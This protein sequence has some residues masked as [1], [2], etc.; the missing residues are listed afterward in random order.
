VITTTAKT[1]ALVEVV[2]GQTAGLNGQASTLTLSG[3]VDVENNSTLDLAGVISNAKGVIT[4]LGA[5]NAT[6]LTVTAAT[7]TLTG[8]GTIDLAGAGNNDI[9]SNNGLQTLINANNLIEGAGNIGD[10]GSLVFVNQSPGVV[11]ANLAT[12]A[13]TI[14]DGQT[15]EN[16]GVLESTAAGGLFN[17]NST[18][19]DTYGTAAGVLNTGEIAATGT[20]HVDLQNSNIYGGTLSTTGTAYI[21]VVSGQTAGL[22][23]TVLG[24]SVNIVA[25]ANFDVNN[26]SALYLYGSIDNA[27]TITLEGAANATGIDLGNSLVT[28]SGGGRLVLGGTGDNYIQ[29][30]QGNC[31]L[32]NVSNTI[33]GSGNIGNGGQMYLTNESAGT[34]DALA[35]GLTI[36]LGGEEM[37]NAGTLEATGGALQVD[38]NVFNTGAIIAKGAN[39]TITGGVDGAGKEEIFGAAEISIASSTGGA[40]AQAVTFESG[41]T[42]VFAIQN[43]QDF[44]G[45]VAGLDTGDAIDLANINFATA[46]ITSYVGTTASGVITVFDGTTVSRLTLEGNYTLANFKLVNDGSNHTEITYNG[47]GQTPKK[48]GLVANPVAQMV[49]AMASLG[50]GASATAAV[51]IGGQSSATPILARP[52]AA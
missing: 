5:A 32:D 50:G 52:L 18:I 10:G 9:T 35:G 20:G 16:N 21:D 37:A 11:N 25:G 47:T 34:I 23:G 19:D 33:S 49:E 27:G 42:G 14:Q 51:P 2:S 48:P 8:A 4:L 29:E 3:A 46:T 22:N 26:N 39:V 45:T 24:Q 43:A 1:P 31:E 17:L 41:S 38:D 30:D 28:L 6:Y 13:L 12:A 15:V 40:A 7:T 36:N 44:T